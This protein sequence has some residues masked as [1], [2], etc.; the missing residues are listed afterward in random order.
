MKIVNYLVLFVVEYDVQKVLHHLVYTIL[1]LMVDLN[2]PV[3]VIMVVSNRQG[4]EIT[5]LQ[6][7]KSK[8][9]QTQTIL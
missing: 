4:L 7:L 3:I 2:Q 1:K 6:K 9:K 8:P 5:L